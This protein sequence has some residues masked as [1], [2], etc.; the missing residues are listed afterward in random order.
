M[1]TFESQQIIDRPAMDI[2]L[3]AADM[4]THTEW[5]DV[6]EVRPLEGAPRAVGA[7]AIERIK[8]GPKQLDVEFETSESIPGQRVAWRSTGSGPIET[9][10]TLDLQADGPNRT[11]VTWSGSF[12][13]R[14]LWRILEPIVAGE[15]R[16]SEASEL[17]RLKERTEHMA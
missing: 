8:F 11:R 13:L 4:A 16:G 9:Q 6:M 10:A 1:I 15:M 3:Y 5:M 2:W 12:G 7:R 14:G 17:R